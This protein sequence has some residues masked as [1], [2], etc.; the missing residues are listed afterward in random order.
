MEEFYSSVSPKGQVTVPQQIRQM[1]GLSVKDRVRF[2]VVGDR[3]FLT[4]VESKIAKH[5]QSIPP[6]KETMD[7]DDAI[8]LVMD[9]HALEAAREGL[10]E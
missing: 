2:R 8:A 1:L 6:M 10:D 4:R 5:A 3:V 9:D 7:I